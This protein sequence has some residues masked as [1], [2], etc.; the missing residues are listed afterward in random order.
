M[1][2]PKQLQLLAHGPL[3]HIDCRQ[4]W[5]LRW[6]TWLLAGQALCHLRLQLDL[7]ADQQLLMV[8]AHHR[9][10]VLDVHLVR[11]EGVQLPAAPCS[12]S[13]RVTVGSAADGRL[14][15]AARPPLLDAAA[16]SYSTPI[17]SASSRRAPNC[18]CMRSSS[19]ASCSG[20]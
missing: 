17:C 7:L 20:M 3:L 11:F 5:L 18:C 12:R 16:G 4:L 8:R 13:A 10:H 9:L 14:P 1:Q 6:L 19:W 2:L 15:A